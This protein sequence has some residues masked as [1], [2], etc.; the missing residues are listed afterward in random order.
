[1]MAAFLVLRSFLPGVKWEPHPGL[2]RQHDSGGLHKPGRSQVSQAVQVNEMPPT[3]GTSQHLLCEGSAHAA[4]N[5]PGVGHVV[6][7]YLQ[8]NG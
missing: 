7:E 6:P 2:F 5:E 4:Q 3:V 8:E 1:M